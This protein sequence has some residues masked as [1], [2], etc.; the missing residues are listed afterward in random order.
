MWSELLQIAGCSQALSSTKAERRSR[1]RDKPNARTPGQVPP[2]CCAV[3]RVAHGFGK[4]ARGAA[5]RIVNV[6]VKDI[7]NV[8]ERGILRLCAD[9]R[10]TH[11]IVEDAEAGT[12]G[13]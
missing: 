12:N 10:G 2:P 3:A 6:A 4:L 9:L 11:E 7:C 8:Y 13:G 5:G 1:S